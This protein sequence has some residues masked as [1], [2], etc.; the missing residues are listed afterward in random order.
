MAS[1]DWP[2][3]GHIQ[4][5][6]PSRSG[7]GGQLVFDKLLSDVENSQNSGTP[8]ES[9]HFAIPR[10]VITVREAADKTDDTPS[11]PDG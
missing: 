7:S 8:F 11:F 6:I 9:V 5:D 3:S 10:A 2:S 4:P 1:V